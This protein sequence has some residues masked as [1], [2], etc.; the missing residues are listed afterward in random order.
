MTSRRQR[1]LLVIQKL[2]GRH[3]V[4]SDLKVL[5]IVPG[6]VAV[7]S[8]DEVQCTERIGGY[9]SQKQGREGKEKENGRTEIQC[10]SMPSNNGAPRIQ[11]A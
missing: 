2:S 9:E 6:C 10:S 3:P 1:V 7:Y 4:I 8:E 11:S 5:G